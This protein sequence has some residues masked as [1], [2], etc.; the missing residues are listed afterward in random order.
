MHSTHHQQVNLQTQRLYYNYLF[1][2][3]MPPSFAINTNNTYGYEQQSTQGMDLS[4]LHTQQSSRTGLRG[5]TEKL[6]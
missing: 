4:D 3:T 1:E 2:A 5:G 6:A